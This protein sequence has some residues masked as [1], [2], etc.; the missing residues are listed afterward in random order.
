M[1]TITKNTLLKQ[2]DKVYQP[3][4]VDGVIYWIEDV[5][6][7]DTSIGWYFRIIPKH[8]PQDGRNFYTRYSGDLRI[9][10]QSQPE[11]D[12]IP[13]VN[14]QLNNLSLIAEVGDPIDLNVYTQ[15]DIEKAIE[16]ILKNYT[17]NSFGNFP[18]GVST[19]SL[20]YSET[21]SQVTEKVFGQINSIS[22]I[23]V[24]YEFNIINYE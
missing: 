24:D 20:N 5:A 9:V 7:F 19:D 4:E 1:K 2:G 6:Y 11:L 22:V 13:I 3:V 8:K 12:G 18:A 15:K 21:T 17:I 14:L 10:A 23:E 16:F